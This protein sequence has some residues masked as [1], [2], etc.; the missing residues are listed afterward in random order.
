MASFAEALRAAGDEAATV[1]APSPAPTPAPAPPGPA[2]LEILVRAGSGAPRRLA[3]VEIWR[4]G[5]F[6]R[7]DTD[8]PPL[9]SRVRLS[10]AH[11][12][13]GARLE[14]AGEVVRHVS[15]ADAAAW[16]MAPGFAVQLVDV[17]PEAKAALAGIA[18]E[19]ARREH[20]PART[21]ETGDARLRTLEERAGLDHYAFLGLPPDAE[22]AEVRRAARAIREDLETFRARPLDADQ[23]RR[24]SALLARLEAAQ[25]A[26]GAPASRL[27]YDAQRGNARGVAR[28]VA[29]GLPDALVA[30]RREALLRAHPERK[31]EAERQLARA[32][33]ARKLGNAQ[34]AAA[35]YE[36]ALAADPLDLATLE[37][38]RTLSVGQRP[39]PR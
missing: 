29:A 2:P 33:V 27:A 15:A 38:V 12:A 13:L 14:L 34:A 31:A 37:L 10:L 26:L 25:G 7:A 22:F 18:D 21:A 30:A 39:S 23:P 1:A 11:P 28:C 8:L 20:A 3:V 4:A 16:R 9:L 17:S 6:I 35:A 5:L 19:G 32:E 24:A 36:A